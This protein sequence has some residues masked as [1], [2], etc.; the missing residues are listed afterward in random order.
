MFIHLPHGTAHCVQLYTIYTNF[1][2]LNVHF[3]YLGLLLQM[4]LFCYEWS[5]KR[6]FSENGSL[7]TSVNSRQSVL[8]VFS[9]T[10]QSVPDVSN[11]APME[12]ML[13]LL[14]EVEAWFSITLG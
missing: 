10:L 9:G 2:G 5:A 11:L 6:E 1:H 4:V 7:F 12:I 3:V 8:S 14:W 13:Y